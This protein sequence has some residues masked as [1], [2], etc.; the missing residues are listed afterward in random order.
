VLP[1][2]YSEKGQETRVS[3]YVFLARRVFHFESW[4]R[5]RIIILF[6]GV[7]S[8]DKEERSLEEETST[9]LPLHIHLDG[10]ADRRGK[11]SQELTFDNTRMKKS[12]LHPA[13]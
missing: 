8:P 3:L 9:R 5:K 6:S 10:L 1:K 13:L 7:E 12:C 11:G 2:K 4:G